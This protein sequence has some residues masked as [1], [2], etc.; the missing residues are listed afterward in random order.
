MIKSY[1]K[2]KLINFWIV[3]ENIK[4]KVKKLRT[5]QKIMYKNWIKQLNNYD[6]RL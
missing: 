4:F 1:Y 6:K 5:Q 2:Y 3:L